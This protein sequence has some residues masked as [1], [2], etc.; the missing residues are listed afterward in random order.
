MRRITRTSR[1]EEDLIDIWRYI[2]KDN[3]SAADKLLDA[4][5]AAFRRLALNP[6]IGRARPDFAPRLRYL[7]VGNYLIFY[8]EVPGGIEI[9]RVLHGA[10]Y[11]P[12]LL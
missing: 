1:A 4:I 12:D 9:V 10:R 2:A 8:C 6:R 3:P 11:L 7:P 5:D